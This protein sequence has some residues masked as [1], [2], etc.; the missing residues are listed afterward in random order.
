MSRSAAAMWVWVALLPVVLVAGCGET[1]DERNPP[2][3]RE[4][5][6]LSGPA[7]LPAIPKSGTGS[8]RI[9]FLLPNQPK[10]QPL[11]WKEAAQLDASKQ[12]GIFT[13]RTAG[14]GES[15]AEFVRRVSQEGTSAMVVV[16]DDAE[17]L[18]P[19]IA[20]ARSRGIQVVTI[21]DQVT[22]DGDPVP[23]IVRGDYG[24]AAETLVE[25]AATDATALG[26][27]SEGPALV[28]YTEDFPEADRRAQALFDALS[29]AGIETIGAGPQAVSGGQYDVGNM[30]LETLKE[31][32]E[33][34]M[35][36]TG[37]DTS[38]LGSTIER[39][40]LPKGTGVSVAGFLV[41]PQ[42][43]D[44]VQGSFASAAAFADDRV[45]G[46]LAYRNAMSLA[47]GETVPDRIVAPMPVRRAPGPPAFGRLRFD[48]NPEDAPLEGFDP[49]KPIQR[50]ESEVKD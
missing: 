8:P 14:D 2:A 13:V 37:D 45:L 21:L 41:D 16:V 28:V 46:I 32:P 35:V 26:K 34:A 27:S 5:G 39:S 50:I 10:T 25:A 4:K 20:E 15:M 29:E 42:S 1:Q 12:N 30:V 11:I 24:I 33:L 47:K 40:E 48:L 44:I 31:R 3:T 36:L 22:A 9:T 38:F 7:D 43:F 23:V 49:T 6:G 18:G 17:T 19:A